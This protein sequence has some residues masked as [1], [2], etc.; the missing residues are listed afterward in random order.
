MTVISFGPDGFGADAADFFILVVSTDPVTSE[1]IVGDLLATGEAGCN[2][3]TQQPQVLDSIERVK[4]TV[5]WKGGLGYEMS[6]GVWFDQSIW[7]PVR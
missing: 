6:R 1:K 4:K 3:P 7:D 2:D 5:E